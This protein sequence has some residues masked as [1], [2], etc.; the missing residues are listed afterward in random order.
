MTFSGLFSSGHIVD[1]ILL[2]MACEFV[3]LR[4]RRGSSIDLV[5]TLLPGV[6]LLLA[7]R[8]A[9][10]GAGWVWVAVFLAASLPAHLLTLRKRRP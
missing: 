7:L 9:L 6:C 5:V 2:F 4:L 8:C 3:V 1:L 10:T